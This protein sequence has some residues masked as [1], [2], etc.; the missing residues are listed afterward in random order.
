LD[1]DRGGESRAFYRGDIHFFTEQ[2]ERLT[3]VKEYERP[4]DFAERV[5]YLSGEGI[6]F[7]GRLSFERTPY[8]IKMLDCFDPRDPT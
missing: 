2:T 8:F 5:R 4:S 1:N 7:P 6:V 3:D